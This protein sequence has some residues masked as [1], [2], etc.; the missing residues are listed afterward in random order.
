MSDLNKGAQYAKNIFAKNFKKYIEQANKT[1]SDIVTDLGITASTVSDWANAKKYPRVDKMQSLADY[2]G[3]LISDLRDEKSIDEI[4]GVT[5][6]SNKLY[7]IPKIGSVKAGYN[8]LAIE[9]IIGYEL[10]DVKNPQE[11]VA[12]NVTGDSM[13]PRICEGDIAIVRKQPDIE[14]GELAV[15][16]INGNEGTLKKVIKKN[17]ALILQPFNNIYETKIIIGEELN[18]VIIYG[19]VIQII[20][21]Y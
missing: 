10:V 14:S 13:E 4:L 20:Q 6:V 18:E 8:G 11:C 12:F 17:K 1:Q 15:I 9:E 21:K 7:C 16:I 2:L 3:V 5:P 19:K